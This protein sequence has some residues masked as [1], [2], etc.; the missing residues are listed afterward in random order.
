MR[1]IVETVE[2]PYTKAT[3]AVYPTV[4]DIDENGDWDGGGFVEEFT[5]DNAR[6]ALK[7][8][9]SWTDKMAVEYAEKHGCT[10]LQLN[11][12][13]DYWV[14]DT[15]YGCDPCVFGAY[16]IDGRRTFYYEN[17]RVMRVR[18]E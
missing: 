2:R 7:Y 10:C 1:I 16:W 8:I 18:P 11:C 4:C 6:D 12:D 5:F 14:G 17:D 13:K 3:F 9:N 15:V